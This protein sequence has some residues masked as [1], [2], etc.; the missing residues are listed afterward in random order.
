MTIFVL[1]ASAA[2]AAFAEQTGRGSRLLTRISE[3]GEI[4]VPAHYYVEAA[5][6]LRG[7]ERGG[8]LDTP[9]M[10]GSLRDLSDLAVTEYSVVGPLLDRAI[11]L[12]ANA[13]VYDALYIAL[14]EQLE[15][16]VVTADTKLAAIP[17]I[18]CSVEIFA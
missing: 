17:G 4:S 18:R 2:V 6:A 12:R 9:A 11:E 5:N 10:L 8:V 13:T 7:L 16:S 3:A 1:D 14:A 15:C